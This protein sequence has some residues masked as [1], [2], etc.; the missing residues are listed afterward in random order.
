M[1][2]GALQTGVVQQP[3]RDVLPDSLPSIEAD[4]VD[5]LD[6]HGALAAAAGDPQHV[7]LDLGQ[8]A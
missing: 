2:S 3:L 5:S 8:T 4:R 6:F 1:A 7:A